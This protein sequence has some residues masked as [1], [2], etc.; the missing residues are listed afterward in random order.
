MPEQPILTILQYNVMHSKNT[1]MA[2][3]FKDDAN[4]HYSVIAIQEPWINDMN[5]QI[6]TTHHPRGDNDLL[7]PDQGRPRCCFFVNKAL[8]PASWTF[9]THSPDQ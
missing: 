6:L 5:K 7:F 8:P 1:V 4:C 9:V 2:P 3:F